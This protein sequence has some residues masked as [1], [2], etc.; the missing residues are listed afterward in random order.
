MNTGSP[1]ISPDNTFP[2]IDDRVY[3]AVR[4]LIL[5]LQGVFRTRPKGAYRWDIDP[6]ISEIIITA[7]DPY[8]SDK[9]NKRP[10]IVVSRTQMTNANTSIG[11]TLS[12]GIFSES[13]TYTDLMQGNLIITVIA[14]EGLEAQNIAYNLFRLIPVFRGMLNRTGRMTTLPGRMSMTPEMPYADVSSSATSPYRRAV[15]VVLPISIQDHFSVDTGQHFSFLHAVETYVNGQL[16][17][18]ITSED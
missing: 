6:E 8:E 1:L 16:T 9:T 12:P 14:R 11:Q 5:W 13:T 15:S 7:H 17:E 18:K 2:E 3:Y 4:A 10:N